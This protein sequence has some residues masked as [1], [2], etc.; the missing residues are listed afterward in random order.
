MS[1]N[2]DSVTAR[3]AGVAADIRRAEAEFGRAQ[4][5]VQLLAVSK[6]KP[7]AAI[8][9]AIAAGQRA[10]GEN[11]L[12]EALEKIEALRDERLEWH[13]IGAIQSNKTRLIAAHFDWVHGVDREKIARRLSEQRR[14]ELAPLNICLQVNPDGEASKAGVAPQDLPALAAAVAELP[15]IRLRGLM[16]IPAPRED[17]DAQRAVCARLRELFETLRQQWPELDTL[18]MGMTGDLRAAVAEGSTMLRIGTAIFGARPPK[19]GTT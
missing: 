2:N 16:A 15:N 14:A 6:T 19:P 7:V 13:F 8:R 5:S 12:D 9:E 17:F 4:G 3:L 10:F 18:S 1:S 11:Y